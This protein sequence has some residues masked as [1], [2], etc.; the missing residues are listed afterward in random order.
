MLVGSRALADLP[1]LRSNGPLGDTPR[2]Q[3][4]RRDGAH[5]HAGELG[6]LRACHH[7][8]ESGAGGDWREKGHRHDGPE[9]ALGTRRASL[10]LEALVE[11]RQA[12][13]FIID[14]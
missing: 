10:F 3:E 5:S 7:A 11:E 13:G 2:H 8:R 9:L 4:Q 1:G 14:G 6:V 12:L